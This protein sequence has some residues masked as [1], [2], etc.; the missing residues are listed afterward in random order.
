MTDVRL[1]GPGLLSAKGKELVAMPVRVTDSEA[2]RL[3]SAGDV[4]DVLV[5]F[6]G[7]SGVSQGLADRGFD[8]GSAG[9]GVGGFGSGF[10]GGFVGRARTVVGQVDVLL[11]RLARSSASSSA[12]GGG[13]VVLAVTPDQAAQLAQAQVQGPLSLVIHPR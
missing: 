5:A 9:S 2:A 13:L 1:L 6:G 3:V 10:G 7:G 11:A 4:V 12:N 8:E